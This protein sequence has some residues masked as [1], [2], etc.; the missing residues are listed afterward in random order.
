MEE[1][2]DM[3]L[4]LDDLI[5]EKEDEELERKKDRK[6]LDAREEQLISARRDVRD[7]AL[8]RRT[9]DNDETDTRSDQATSSKTSRAKKKRVEDE[10]MDEWKS[11]VAA[12][13]KQRHDVD[14]KK[15]Q[16]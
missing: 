16:V 13:L 14:E 7:M 1:F 2:G 5:Q 4:L 9:N 10:S 15:L 3:E 6:E 11:M 8:G 12:E